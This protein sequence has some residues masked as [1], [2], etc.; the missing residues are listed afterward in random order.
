MDWRSL[1]GCCALKAREALTVSRKTNAIAGIQ[2]PAACNAVGIVSD[3]KHKLL[4]SVLH[5]MLS[6][7]CYSE[8][9]NLALTIFGPDDARTPG[10]GSRPTDAPP[11][12]RTPHGSHGHS[13]HST[14]AG[15]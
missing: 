8:Y 6:E 11:L 14:G 9:N 5:V 13:T 7:S 12:V 4:G 10:G 3:V 2:L 15:A 1:F